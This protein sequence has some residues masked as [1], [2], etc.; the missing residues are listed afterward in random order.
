[1]RA[2]PFAA[3]AVMVVACPCAFAL[4]VPA[5]LTRTLAVLARNGELRSPQDTD[6]P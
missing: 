5:A 4:A 1:M 6:R 3:L 2:P